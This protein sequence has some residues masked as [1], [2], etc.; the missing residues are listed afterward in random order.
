[1]SRCTVAMLLALGALLAGCG[2]SRS[3]KAGGKAGDVRV[4]RLAN[5]NEEPNE[6]EVFAREVAPRVA[7]RVG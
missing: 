2:E 4:L 5:A 6:L 1:M 3:D 7:R